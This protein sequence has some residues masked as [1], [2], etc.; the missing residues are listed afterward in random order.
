MYNTRVVS[1]KVIEIRDDQVVTV[2]GDIV[3]TYHLDYYMMVNEDTLPLTEQEMDSLADRQQ[4]PLGESASWGL[5]QREWK[6]AFTW[7]SI[8]KKSTNRA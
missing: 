6:P 8:W 7:L 3:S 1:G 5:L 4:A 2:Q